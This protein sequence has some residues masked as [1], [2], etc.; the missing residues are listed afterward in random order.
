MVEWIELMGKDIRIHRVRS[1]DSASSSMAEVGTIVKCNLRG[2]YYS[3]AKEKR[4]NPEPFE[5]ME[6]QYYQ[7]GEG[8]AIPGLELPLRHSRVG[9]IIRCTSSARFAY[10]S[11]GRCV[12]KLHKNEDSTEDKDGNIDSDFVPI[13]LRGNTPIVPPNVDLEY[14]IEILGHFGDRDINPDTIR[15]HQSEVDCVS[16]DEEKRQKLLHR[17]LTVQ[18]MNYRKDC[19]NRWFNYDEF[20]RAAKA[21]SA[22]TKLAES[23]F[24]SS[25][26]NTVVDET[27]TLEDRI[28]AVEANERAKSEPIAAE[29]VD[30]VSAYVTCLNNL[31]ACKVSQGEFAAAKDLCVKVLQFSPGNGKALLRA[32]RSCLALDVRNDNCDIIKLFILIILFSFLHSVCSISHLKNANCA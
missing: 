23:Y 5:T 10:G 2:Y 28:K 8:D 24:N 30:V 21:Y 19:G 6:N 18:L 15:K 29:D 7:I 20:G 4:L 11:I 31:A 3:I 13:K 12:D 27:N 14:E 9:E 32:A 17:L 22:A 1:V 16:N 26:S 25:T